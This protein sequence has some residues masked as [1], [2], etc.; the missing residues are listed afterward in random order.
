MF[1]PLVDTLSGNSRP[2]ALLVGFLSRPSW[3]SFDRGRIFGAASWPLPTLY[4]TVSFAVRPSLSCVTAR[5]SRRALLPLVSV[6][7][8]KNTQK[9]RIMP[10]FAPLHVI[11]G[12]FVSIFTVYH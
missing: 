10:G 8:D 11:A 7:N 4:S 5:S 9:F 12:I 6:I 1:A 2:T 3:L